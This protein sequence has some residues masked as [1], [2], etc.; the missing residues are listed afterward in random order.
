MRQLTPPSRQQ[1]CES[2][3]TTTIGIFSFFFNVFFCFFVNLNDHEGQNVST[4][5]LNL[6]QLQAFYEY[7]INP[8]IQEIHY[9][10]LQVEFFLLNLAIFYIGKNGLQR[11]LVR[12]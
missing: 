5:L 9:N 7:L 3:N 11:S 8:C 2:L 6:R 12:F 4:N 1:Q 10:L